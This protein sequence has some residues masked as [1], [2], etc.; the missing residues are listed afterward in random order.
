MTIDRSI[1]PT[2]D[3]VR[4]L[5]D[6][7]A[8]GPILM[9]NFL[10]F[11]DKAVYPSDFDGDPNVSGREAYRRYEKAFTVTVG[12]ISKAEVIYMGPVEQ[13]FIGDAAAPEADWDAMLV[14]RYPA[15]ENFLAM[16][17]DAEYRRA[18]VHRYAALERTVLLRC[19]G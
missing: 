18:L 6:S 4:A 9:F 13:V 10:K 15:T 17:A 12:H 1:D 7:G 16:M 5:R 14:V 2:A 8:S 3:Q 11:R 19:A